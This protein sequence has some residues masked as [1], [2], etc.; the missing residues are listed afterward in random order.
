MADKKKKVVVVPED[1]YTLELPRGHRASFYRIHEI[2]A[3]RARPFQVM[4]AHM[5]PILR[6]AVRARQVLVDGHEAVKDEEFDGADL[7]LSLEDTEKLFRLNDLALVTFLKSWTLR[8]SDGPIP[9]PSS[10]DE[11]LELPIPPDTFA[12]LEERAS[13][14]VFEADDGGFTVDSVEDPDSPTG[15]SAL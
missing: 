8:T 7:S 11:L 13:K 12:V 3:G 9:L 6:A 2:T 5:N 14:L 4:M 15:G 1:L 10:A